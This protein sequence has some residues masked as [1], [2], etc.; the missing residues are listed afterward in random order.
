MESLINNI[1]IF[2]NSS[3]TLCLFIFNL[4]LFWAGNASE[5]LSSIIQRHGPFHP[6]GGVKAAPLAF[7]TATTKTRWSVRE[8]LKPVEGKYFN[9][10]PSSTPSCKCG[11]R[12][13]LLPRRERQPLQNGQSPRH[14]IGRNR[15][16]DP[17]NSLS[18][19]CIM[20]TP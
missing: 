18:V 20:R 2:P 6:V 15:H 19:F 12:S 5:N 1:N 9:P 11:S 10:E 17:C 14:S 4:I 13:R 8:R 16:L 3:L 7:V